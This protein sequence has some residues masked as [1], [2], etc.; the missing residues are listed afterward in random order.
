MFLQPE[1]ATAALESPAEEPG[2]PEEPSGQDPISQPGPDVVVAVPEAQEG[3]G[4]ANG[5][6]QD[7][8][9]GADRKRPLEE[10]GEGAREVKRQQ[11]QQQQQAQ[12]RDTVFR[13]LV[14]ATRV[15]AVIGK[16]GAI[17][18]EIRSATKARIRVCEGVPNC[19]ERVIVISARDSTAEDSNQAQRALV[20]VHR[21]VIDAEMESREQSGKPFYI[22][23]RLLVN[24]TQAGSIIGKGGCITKDIRE[25]TG[26]FCKILPQEDLPVCALHNDRVVLIS[27]QSEQI[28][29]ALLIVCRQIRDNPPREAPGGPP[30][31]LTIL[32]NYPVHHGPPPPIPVQY[33]YG[34]PGAA[35]VFPPAPPYMP[36]APIPYQHP[37][38]AHPP[39]YY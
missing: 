32:H 21:R 22:V 39:V 13:L 33:P 24:H 3:N 30:P 19:D 4:S 25:T 36:Q 8:G 28:K 20:E 16:Q 35:P 37:P 5:A 11:Q 9:A 29:A 10:E 6:P 12:D 23:T 34:I 15:G 26:A 27:G 1:Q 14:P 31:S 2:E 38:A 18:R 17:V 7:E